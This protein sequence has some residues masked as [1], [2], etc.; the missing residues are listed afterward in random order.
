MQKHIYNLKPDI[1]K[2][3]DKYFKNHFEMVKLP[4]S[5]D[6][7]N[8]MPPIYDQGQLGACQSFAADAIDAYIKG[9]SFTP[10][11]LFTY[12]NCRSIEGT[13]DEDSGGTL[14]DTCA[15]LKKYGVC[16]SLLWAYD[17]AKF[18]QKPPEAAYT[19]AIVDKDNLTDYFR[20]ETIDEIKQ[21][22]AQGHIPYIGITVFESFESANCMKTGIIPAPKGK[23]LGGHALDITAYY[24][25]PA[26]SNCF[27]K[28]TSGYVVIRNSWGTSVGKDGY[29]TA[30]YEVLEKLLVDAWVIIS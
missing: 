28:K 16:D 7:T 6:L 13:V 21:A 1:K 14:A 11:H 12:Y 27:F 9:Y 4:P 5:V 20:I 19:N 22:L 23:V 24:D 29:F 17:I 30:T 10:S 8:K 3:E 18:T 15:A 26:K 25:T 2:P